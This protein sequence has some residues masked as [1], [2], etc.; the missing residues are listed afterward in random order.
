[1]KTF[2]LCIICLC[3][4]VIAGKIYFSKVQTITLEKKVYSMPE[5]VTLQEMCDSLYG[6]QEQEEMKRIKSD[7]SNYEEGL[8]EGIKKSYEA[9]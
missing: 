8:R 1:M 2:W 9:Y 5:N 3:L 6:K 4:G 7:A